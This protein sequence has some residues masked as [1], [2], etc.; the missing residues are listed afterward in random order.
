MDLKGL[1]VLMVEDEPL[2]AELVTEIPIGLECASRSGL[3]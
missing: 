2:I 1:R 3:P